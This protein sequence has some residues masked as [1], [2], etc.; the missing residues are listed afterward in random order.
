V[1]EVEAQ[2][3]GADQRAGLLDVLAEHLAQRMVQDVRAGVVAADGV[4]TVGVDGRRGR[5]AP[6]RISPSTRAMWRRSPGSA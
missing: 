1:A 5:V 4:A 2:A 3:V 6:T